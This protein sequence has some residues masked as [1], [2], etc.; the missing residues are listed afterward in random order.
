MTLEKAAFLDYRSIDAND[1]SRQSLEAVIA[2]WHWYDETEPAMATR[3]L[4]GMHIAV[5]NK[6]RLDAT[7]MDASP[8]LKLICIAATGTDKIDLNAAR[9]RGICVSNVT[10]YATPAV[11][12]HVFALLLALKTGLV[13]YHLDVQS[14]DWQSARQFCLLEHPI[15]EITGTTMGI[16]GFGELGKAVAQVAKAFSMNVMV[17]DRP[18]SEHQAGRYPLFEVLQRSDVVSIHLPLAEN[19]RNL[20]GEAE[21]A[22]MKP[23]ALLINTA[24]GGI[25]NEIALAAALQKGKLGG[26]G[27]DVLSVEPPKGG[28]PLLDL[29]LPNLI[30]TPHTAWASKQA[31]QRLLDE[32]AKNITAYNAGTPRNR[33]A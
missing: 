28:N 23:D 20:I 9:E 29:K 25:V 33:V 26:A 14:G 8:Q 30:V 22:M 7:I 31:R 21:L 4:Q 19:T 6:V 11:V 27:F 32:V 2:D 3:H 16:L 1:L 13:Q 10:S 15:N 18:G 5:S 12:Q 17:A 24:R